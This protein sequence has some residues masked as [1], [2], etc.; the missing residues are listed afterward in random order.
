MRSVRGSR[1]RLP[2]SQEC[3]RL[4]LRQELA[5][6]K[7][8]HLTQSPS[9]GTKGRMHVETVASSWTGCVRRSECRIAVRDENHPREIA[10]DQR[11]ERSAQLRK[12][13]GQVAVEDLL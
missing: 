6:N 8:S 4:D 1:Q 10:A 7:F 3:K 12:I 2:P 5:G 13:A 11:F 9:I